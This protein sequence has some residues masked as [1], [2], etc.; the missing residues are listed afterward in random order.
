MSASGDQPYEVGT[1]PSFSRR[2]PRTPKRSGAQSRAGQPRAAR[3]NSCPSTIALSFACA[4][5]RAIYFI[6]SRRDHQSLGRNEL[7]RRAECGRDRRRALDR[8]STSRSITPRNE[9]VFEEQAFQNRQIEPGL[10][11]LD[12]YPASGE[13]VL[14]LRQERVAGRLVLHDVGVAENTDAAAVVPVT[15]TSARLS[16]ARPYWR[17][18]S[19]RA[20]MLG[21]V[22]LDH[23][24]A[25]CEEIL[26]GLPW[27]TPPP[28]RPIASGLLVGVVSVSSLA[29]SW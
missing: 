11:G 26:E 13:A 10:R 20:C 5:S 24:S 9:M 1:S 29:G 17:A 8:G 14:Q 23:V 2:S 12:R 7:E 27:L 28:R 3:T 4:I 22:D 6:R 19:G 16:A 18:R 25:G 21:L 15:S